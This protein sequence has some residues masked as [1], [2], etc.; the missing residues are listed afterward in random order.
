MEGSSQQSNHLRSSHD[1]IHVSLFQNPIGELKLAHLTAATA[2]FHPDNVIVAV[3]VS[4][5]NCRVDLC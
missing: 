5:K 3:N 2:S 4:V 1:I